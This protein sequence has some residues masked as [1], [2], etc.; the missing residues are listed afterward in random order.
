VLYDS[1]A[2]GAGYCQMVMGHGLRALLERAI[3]VLECSA[4]C[5]HSCRACLQTRFNGEKALICSTIPEIFCGIPPNRLSIFDESTLKASIKA[6]LEKHLRGLGFK[7]ENGMLSPAFGDKESSGRVAAHQIISPRC[8]PISGPAYPGG[9][10][11]T[12]QA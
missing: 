6:R 9:R 11:I 5:S 7:Q 3:N 12:S 1:V 4:K 8:L 10:R 2:G